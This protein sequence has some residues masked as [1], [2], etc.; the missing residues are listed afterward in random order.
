MKWML[1]TSV[2][3]QLCHPRKFPEIKLWFRGLLGVR[4]H[5]IYL[6]EIADF[7]LR[8]ELERLNATASLRVLDGLPT[9]IAY[10]PI[11]TAMMRDAAKLWAHLW[12]IGQPIG[13]AEALGADTILAAKAR[14]M[15]AT[16]ITDNLAHVGRMVAAVRWQEV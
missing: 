3:G 2:L 9:E 7:E 12:N 16:V 5:Q 13:T 11:D 15:D 4:Q 1:D 8:R 6:P 10:L 14:A